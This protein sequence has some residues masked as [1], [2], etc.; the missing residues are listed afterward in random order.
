MTLQ[1]ETTLVLTIWREN[2]GGGTVGMQS[3]ANVI[4]NRAKRDGSDVAD[5]CL[6]RLQFSSMTAPN[7]PELRLGPDPLDPAD[8]AAWG[9]A[10]NI[11]DQ[12]AFNNLPDLT[13]GATLYYAPNGLQ[14]AKTITLA[15]VTYPF[16]Q[17]WNEAAV[18]FTTEIAGQLFFTE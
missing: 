18:T 12:A 17:G 4:L 16:P 10:V 8:W 1:D 13:G 14:S 3:V 15:G 11:V 6:K 9:Q 7:D 2:R 5:E